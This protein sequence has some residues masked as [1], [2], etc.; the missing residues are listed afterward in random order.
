MQYNEET[1]FHFELN[2]GIIFMLDYY[3]EKAV[4][5]R[6]G[7]LPV[8]VHLGGGVSVRGEDIIA[9][10][11]LQRQQSLQ[12]ETLI[13]QFRRKGQLRVLTG[14]TKTLVICRQGARD[15]GY[16]CSVGARTL[17]KRMEERQ[18]IE[19]REVQHG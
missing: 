11:D 13:G 6:E 15:A 5:R 9:L 4:F 7:G 8:L 1:L 16:L 2:F 19:L 3:G 14:K 17:R 18:L 12:I 10:C